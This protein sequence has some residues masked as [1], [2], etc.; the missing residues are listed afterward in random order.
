[1]FRSYAH[2]FHF[3]MHPYHVAYLQVLRPSHPSPLRW[4]FV[5]SSLLAAPARPVPL[6][7]PWLL[8][9]VD[10]LPSSCAWLYSTVSSTSRQLTSPCPT[11]AHSPT[12]SPT[13]RDA[14]STTATAALAVFAQ[15]KSVMLRA[16]LWVTAC[17][18]RQSTSSLLRMVYLRWTRFPAVSDL[19]SCPWV[20]LS[21]PTFTVGSCWHESL[22]QI[23]V[24]A[25]HTNKCMSVANLDGTIG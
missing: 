2:V 21:V 25:P 15:T 14:L 4:D 3:C 1:M 23:C 7:C 6:Q 16:W 18:R 24:R 17:R 10:Q 22:P 12:H 19:S 11:N 8:K 5:A 13:R 20:A 9:T